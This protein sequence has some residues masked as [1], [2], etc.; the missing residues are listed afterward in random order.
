M[1]V[2][3]MLPLG[4]MADLALFKNRVKDYIEKDSNDTYQNN[5]EY[6]FKGIEL[7]LS[8]S[9]ANAGLSMGYS[10]MDAQDKS[11]GSAVDDLEYRPRHKFTLQGNYEFDFG[12]TAHASIMKVMDQVYYDGADKADLGDYLLVDVRLEQRIFKDNCFVYVGADNLFD[13]DYE[14]SN[15]FPQA[16]RTAY[17]GVRVRF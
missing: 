17:A 10:W 6:H 15:E 11:R 14:E 1:G 9:F 5:D 3:Q 12:L 8:K 4:I 16:G 2:T 13:E 7:V